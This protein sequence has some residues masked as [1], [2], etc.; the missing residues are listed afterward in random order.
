VV[1]ANRITPDQLGHTLSRLP[2][3]LPMAS[4]LTKFD[5]R[6]AGTSYGSTSHYRY[7][8]SAWGL[9]AA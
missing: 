7:G 8:K 4:I 2:E 3:T 9:E 6:K 5:A 1:E